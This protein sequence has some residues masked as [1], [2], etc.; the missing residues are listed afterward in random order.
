MSVYFIGDP[1]L[2]HQNIAKFRPFVKSAEHNNNLFVSQWQKRIHKNDIVFVM[3]DAAFG[4]NGLDLIGNLRGRKILIKG[5]HDDI[6]TTAAQAAVF[7]DIHGMLKYKG[8][9]LTHCPIHPDEMRGRKGNIHGHVHNKSIHRKTWYGKRVLDRRYFN[10]CVDVV[11]P[12]TGSYFTSL[13]T[14]KSYFA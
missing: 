1:H 11:Y 4:Q 6:V 10:T 14:I 12:A 13:D 2:D 5:N 8:F 3:G 9:W 7:E